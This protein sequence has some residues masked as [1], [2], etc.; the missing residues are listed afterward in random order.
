[1][2]YKS[3]YTFAN[4]N[5]NECLQPIAESHA[6][7]WLNAQFDECDEVISRLSIALNCYSVLVQH[8]F[9]RDI[10]TVI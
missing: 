10:Y 9:L 7:T 4:V 2:I 8:Q 6:Y 5:D 1:M 3:Q